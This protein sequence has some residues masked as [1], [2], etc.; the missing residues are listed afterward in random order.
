MN[1]FFLLFTCVCVLKT[2]ELN[3]EVDLVILS[4]KLKHR[5]LN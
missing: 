4:I 2:Y 1:F 5:K 3:Q